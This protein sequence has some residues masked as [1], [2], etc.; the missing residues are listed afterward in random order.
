[1]ILSRKSPLNEHP[2]TLHMNWPRQRSKV[3]CVYIYINKM[4]VCVRVRAYWIMT[5]EVNPNRQKSIPS[6]QRGCVKYALRDICNS[7]I[8]SG[9]LPITAHE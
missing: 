2:D 3:D 8:V 1:M 4:C 6:D 7:P 9:S 5:P